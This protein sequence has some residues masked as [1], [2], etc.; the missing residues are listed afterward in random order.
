MLRERGQGGD[1][2]AWCP[3]LSNAFLTVKCSTNDSP[4]NKHKWDL[5]AT[6]TTLPTNLKAGNTSCSLDRTQCKVKALLPGTPQ[7]F[8]ISPGSPPQGGSESPGHIL[9]HHTG[10]LRGKLQNSEGFCAEPAITSVP[11]PF[12]ML[13]AI[14]GHKHFPLPQTLFLATPPPPQLILFTPRLV[15]HRKQLG[16]QETM[17]VERQG[18]CREQACS[19]VCLCRTG[20]WPWGL[21]FEEVSKPYPPPAGLRRAEGSLTPRRLR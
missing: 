15:F 6:R 11:R 3:P 2:Y 20:Y 4:Q 17:P 21:P 10:L 1:K 8:I 18:D 7:P 19:P 5:K 9:F 12:P 14:Q 16:Q 13:V